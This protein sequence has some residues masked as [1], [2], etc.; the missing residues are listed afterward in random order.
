MGLMSSGFMTTK[1]CHQEPV[2]PQV[3]AAMGTEN[4]ELFNGLKKENVK[5]QSKVSLYEET[6]SRIAG[7]AYGIG[8]GL[9]HVPAE[10]D[11][12]KGVEIIAAENNLIA[13]AV[14]EPTPE[15]RAATDARTIAILQNDLVKKNELYN[16]ALT[17][18]DTAKKDN[19][20][21]TEDVK[22]LEVKN[23]EQ[24][25][26]AKKERDEA[27]VATDAAF[28]DF[29]ATIKKIHDEQ[30]AKERRMWINILRYGGFGFIA[31]GVIALALT[32]GKSLIPSGILIAGGA[33]TILIGIS[34]DIVT[35]Q[36][37]FPYA[38][39]FVGLLILVG[40][41]WFLYHIWEKLQ[42]AKKAN[43]V[44]NDMKTEAEILKEKGLDSGAMAA[45]VP[46]LEYR[47]GKQWDHV[48]DTHAVKEGLDTKQK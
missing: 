18:I 34:I 12:A 39:G 30:A 11:N 36:W 7:N 40:I 1:G 6:M 42:F 28:A 23:K 26:K 17:K 33:L 37:W 10:A 29:Q 19:E 45:A 24:E 38:A 46:H 15:Q 9:K 5:L 43:G 35:S 13:K 16:G 44:F 4:T 31:M 8:I 14:G 21:L 47:F 32:Q 3:N 41:G 48:L 22:A 2:A 25:V 20:K 27:K